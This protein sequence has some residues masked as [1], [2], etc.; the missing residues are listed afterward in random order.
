VVDNHKSFLSHLDQSSEAVFITAL[1]LYNKGLDVRINAI[2]KAPSHNDWKTHVDNGDIFIYKND[3][4][5]R[6]EVKG[7]SCDFTSGLDWKFK[8]FIVC[9]KNSFDY[10]KTTPFAYFILNKNRTHLAIVKTDTRD[11]WEIVSRKD[12]RYKDISQEFYTCPLD[13]IE[14]ILI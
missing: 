12:S 7:L 10:A 14:W 2:K 8:D 3:K 4:E 6:I 13:K 1:Y 9:S 11:S 5:Y